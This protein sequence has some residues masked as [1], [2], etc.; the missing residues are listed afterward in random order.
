MLVGKL[1]YAKRLKG[2]GGKKSISMYGLPKH[3]TVRI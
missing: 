1:N 2:Q 3:N